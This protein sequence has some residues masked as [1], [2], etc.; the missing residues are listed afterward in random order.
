M[1]KV[2]M[3]GVDLT[4]EQEKSLAETLVA[5][6][7]VRER[8]GT[9]KPTTDLV[10]EMLCPVCDEG[11]LRYSVSSYNNHLWGCCSTESCVRWVE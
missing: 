11:T 1:S 4:P 9:R 8:I 5:Y 3:G 7:A 10:G 2:G 6:A